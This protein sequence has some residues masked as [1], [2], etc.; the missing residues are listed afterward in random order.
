MENEKNDLRKI[1]P[2][3]LQKIKIKAIELRD[4]GIS[5]KGVAQKFNL[6]PTVLSRWYSKHVKNYRQPQKTLKRGR[7]RGTH[8]KLTNYQENMIIKKLQELPDLL[9]KKFVQKII[10]EKYKI[11]VPITTVGDYLKEWGVNSSFIKD[12]E[13]EFV[14]NVGIDDF[15]LTKQEIMKREGILI[16][17]NVTNCKLETDISL[18]SISTR[19]AKN[20][21]IFKFYN[22]QVHPLDLMNFIKQISASFTKHLYVIFST[23]N[24]QFSNNNYRFENSEKITFIYNV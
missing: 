18:Y 20:K 21:L 10:E 19:S 1:S 17:V 2:E 22:K 24:I 3:K 4:Q 14:A 13:N 12:F 11:K 23:K 16:W 8:K 5:N 9:D 7:K 6:D 15:Q